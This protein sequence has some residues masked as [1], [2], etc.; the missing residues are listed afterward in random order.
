LG[1][2]AKNTGKEKEIDI[3]VEVENILRII[4]VGTTL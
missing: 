4:K 1:K 3:E 2:I